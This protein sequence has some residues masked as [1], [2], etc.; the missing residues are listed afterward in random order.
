M[1]VSDES[2]EQ[3]F[4]VMSLNRAEQRKLPGLA[5]LRQRFESLW[6]DLPAKMREIAVDLGADG[7][8]AAVAA[9]KVILDHWQLTG[10]AA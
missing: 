8:M 7:L 1:S 9:G 6:E 4:N 5:G 3:M 10:P 2:L